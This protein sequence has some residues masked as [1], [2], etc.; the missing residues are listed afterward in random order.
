MKPGP[1]RTIDVGDRVVVT[2]PECKYFMQEGN[3][4]EYIPA[5]ET[6]WGS[7]IRVRFEDDNTRRFRPAEVRKITNDET[8]KDIFL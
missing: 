6:S 7:Y 4:I 1:T 8:H 5:T 3:V 2:V